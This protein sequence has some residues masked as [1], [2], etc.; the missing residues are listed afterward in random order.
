MLTTGQLCMLR[1]LNRPFELELLD[2]FLNRNGCSL[3]ELEMLERS[4]WIAREG[5]SLVR[6]KDGTREY[7]RAKKGRMF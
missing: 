7:N 2:I 4:N 6:T 1:C 5:G 3:A